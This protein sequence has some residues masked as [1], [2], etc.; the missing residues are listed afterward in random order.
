VTLAVWLQWVSFALG[1]TSALLRQAWDSAA[2]PWSIA[3]A[4]VGLYSALLAWL[5]FKIGRGRNWARVVYTILTLLGYLSMGTSWSA[6]SGSYHG[7]V[8]L[9]AIDV[10]DALVDIGGLYFMFT[11]AAN[12]WFRPAQASQDT[13]ETGK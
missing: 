5:I 1:F 8:S 7:H 2:M 10:T 13:I 6:Y 11:R 9:I 4:S 3:L 12:A